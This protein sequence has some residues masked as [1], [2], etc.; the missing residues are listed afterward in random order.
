MLESFLFGPGSREVDQNEFGIK[1]GDR[2]TERIIGRRRRA[3]FVTL[4]HINPDDTPFHGTTDDAHTD[5]SHTPDQCR[6]GS[7]V[8]LSHFGSAH[9]G[10]LQSTGRGGCGCVG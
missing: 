9:R 10:Q 6:L 5:R 1:L 3:N 8:C 7:H 4:I 2:F